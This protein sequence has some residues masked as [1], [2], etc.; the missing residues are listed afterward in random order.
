MLIEHPLYEKVF[1][2]DYKKL[3]FMSFL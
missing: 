3:L 1:S 2:I